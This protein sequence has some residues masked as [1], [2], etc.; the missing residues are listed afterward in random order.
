MVDSVCYDGDFGSCKV[1][2][3]SGTHVNGVVP[4]LTI[5]LS[6]FKS[7]NFILS[8]KLSNVTTSFELIAFMNGTEVHRK[9][10]QII[11]LW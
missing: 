4:V 5:K 9:T 1:W 10:I 8:N 3:S 6:C 7:S 11:P 2:D